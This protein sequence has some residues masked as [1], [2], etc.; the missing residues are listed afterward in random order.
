MRAH[1]PWL[2]QGDI[3]GEVPT[4]S[5]ELDRAGDIEVR[6]SPGPAV[7]L[8]HDCALDKPNVQRLQFAR[9]R[10]L[11]ALPAD[12]QGNL[13]GAAKK[14]GPFDSLYL[15]QI[16][17][18]NETFILLSDPYYLPAEYFRLALL[19][20]GAHPEAES[21]SAKYT[22]PQQNDTRVGR[23][24]EEQLDLLRRKMLAFWTR[25]KMPG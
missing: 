17:Q 5:V 6:S 4:I 25:L 13:R 19:L 11:S 15:G 3:L 1:L 7:L 18:F 10:V 12:Q 23:I 24:D 20:H 21:E 8:T 22:T 9:L 14:V 2:S 16:P